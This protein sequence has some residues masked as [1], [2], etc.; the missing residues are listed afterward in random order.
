MY[1]LNGKTMHAHEIDNFEELLEH[2]E[3]EANSDFAMGFISGMKEKYE[4]FGENTYV[5][6]KQLA[7]LE[8]IAKL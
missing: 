1:N 7:L 4:K 5:S 6:E 8:R 2:A 3:S